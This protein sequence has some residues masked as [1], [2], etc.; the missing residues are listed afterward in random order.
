MERR[1]PALAVGLVAAVEDGAV[2]LVDVGRRPGL[3]G[4]LPARDNLDGK[5]TLGDAD[6]V[7]RDQAVRRLTAVGRR[8]RAA[9]DVG[10]KRA[11]RLER[12]VLVRRPSVGRIPGSSKRK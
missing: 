4:V 3:T 1:R 2:E 11:E 7:G 12:D 5:R 6:L 9:R 10:G 8:E